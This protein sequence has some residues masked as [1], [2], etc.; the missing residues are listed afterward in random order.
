MN[1]LRNGSKSWL[2]QKVNVY[3][4]QEIRVSPHLNKFDVFTPESGKK[5]NISNIE[6]HHKSSG[7]S[8]FIVTTPWLRSF[9]AWWIEWTSSNLGSR[10]KLNR[11]SISNWCHLTLREWNVQVQ[12]EMTTGGTAPNNW[13]WPER[14]SRERKMTSPSKIPFT[15]WFW[16]VCNALCILRRSLKGPE[17]SC[18][19]CS[20]VARGSK[21]HSSKMIWLTP[22]QVQKE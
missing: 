19:L 10:L 13:Q 4:V 14:K 7:V 18:R 2:T 5:L 6:Q 15:M 12:A 21:H 3:T 16:F 22:A 20:L 9:C 17:P 8:E 1:E 11:S